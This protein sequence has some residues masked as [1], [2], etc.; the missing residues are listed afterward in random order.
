[1]MI[2]S[3]VPAAFLGF[4]A[5]RYALSL[6]SATRDDRDEADVSGWGTGP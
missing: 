4:L 2:W 3:I 5:V 1:M 6:R